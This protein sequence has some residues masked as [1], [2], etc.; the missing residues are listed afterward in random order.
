MSKTEQ[1]IPDDYWNEEQS[2]EQKNKNFSSN[3]G[4]KKSFGFESIKFA[5]NSLTIWIN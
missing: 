4:E 3:I 5:V 1:M 2:S